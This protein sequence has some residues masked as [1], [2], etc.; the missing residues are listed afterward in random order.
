MT[1]K[2]FEGSSK[3]TPLKKIRL[4]RWEY[5]WADAGSIICNDGPNM[6]WLPLKGINPATSIGVSNLNYE[7]DK[8]TIAKFGNNVKDLF[9]KISS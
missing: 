3:N 2:E 9:D 5:E 4:H 7:I 1:A 6:I 8:A